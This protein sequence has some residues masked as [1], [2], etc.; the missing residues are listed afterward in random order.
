MRS[1][2]DGEAFETTSPSSEEGLAPQRA[3]VPLE[4]SVQAGGLPR[5]MVVDESFLPAIG[6]TLVAPL[7]G[8]DLAPPLAILGRTRCLGAPTVEFGQHGLHR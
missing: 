2:I 5:H 4:H 1:S 8:S 7:A 3:E 6:A